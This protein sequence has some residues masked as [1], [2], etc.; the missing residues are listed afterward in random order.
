MNYNANV[1]N[2]PEAWTSQA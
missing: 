1:V 2:L